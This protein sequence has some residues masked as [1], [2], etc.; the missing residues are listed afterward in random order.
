[1]AKVKPPPDPRAAPMSTYLLPRAPKKGGATPQVSIKTNMHLIVE[2]GLQV[3]IFHIVHLRAEFRHSD[4]D[5]TSD[6]LFYLFFWKKWH[7]AD[8]QIFTLQTSWCHQDHFLLN[9]KYLYAYALCR[10]RA[11][12]FLQVDWLKELVILQ[13]TSDKV[14]QSWRIA[15]YLTISGKPNIL[16][17]K[18]FKF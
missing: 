7:R 15:K 6:F 8:S 13:T 12:L 2:F 9:F 18:Y 17:F 14:I 3:R 10:M 5:V 4:N 1:M 16:H 11:T